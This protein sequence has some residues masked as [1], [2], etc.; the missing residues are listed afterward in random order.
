MWVNLPVDGTTLDVFSGNGTTNALLP[1]ELIRFQASLQPQMVLLNWAT[2]SEI[3]NA[4]F[5]IQRSID[6][7]TF[8]KI[9]FVEGRGSSTIIN[10]YLF[11]DFEVQKDM[12]YYYRLK[13]IDYDGRFEFSEVVTISNSSNTTTVG[14]LYPNP[15]KSNDLTTKIFAEARNDIHISIF[16]N[17][18]K[19]ISIQRYTIEKG[20]NLISLD[21]TK[22]SNGLYWAKF[23]S[24]QNIISRSF[25][26]QK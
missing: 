13:Q 4:G 22:L 24:D 23:V 26:V 17:S 5:E 16:E 6:G 11:E 14:E 18:G 21:I 25:S 12:Q 19:L 10:E 8:E 9:D 1:A 20:N 15:V 7:H 2:A 3:N